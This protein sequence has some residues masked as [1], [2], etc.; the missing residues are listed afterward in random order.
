MGECSRCGMCCMASLCEFGELEPVGPTG[1]CS[2]LQINER[3]EMVCTNEEAIAAYVGSGCIFMEPK[4]ADL[5]EFHMDYYD[6]EMR[7]I[8][9]KDEIGIMVV[10]EQNEE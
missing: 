1:E 5:Y 9:L 7:K 6:V 2:Y 8:N 10:D 3:D 4:A